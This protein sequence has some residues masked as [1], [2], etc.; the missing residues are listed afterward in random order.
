MRG[1]VGND[2]NVDIVALPAQKPREAIRSQ[3]I[4]ESAARSDPPQD[5]LQHARIDFLLAVD[6]FVHA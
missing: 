3:Q 6:H 2:Q 1:T 5:P 4:D